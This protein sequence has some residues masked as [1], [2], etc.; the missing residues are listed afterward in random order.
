M[1]YRVKGKWEIYEGAHHVVGNTLFSRQTL[2]MCVNSD[3]Q[4]SKLLINISILN[5]PIADDFD[6]LIALNNFLTSF[7]T[8][9][10]NANVS[11][12]GN[13]GTKSLI[14]I[15]RKHIYESSHCV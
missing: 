4:A 14:R 10:T 6:N 15:K 12:Q 13:H 3:I 5:R 1:I 2:K 9:L 7:S 8:T 11:P